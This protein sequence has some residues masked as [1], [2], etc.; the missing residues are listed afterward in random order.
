MILYDIKNLPIN[1]YNAMAVMLSGNM[2][3]EPIFTTFPAASKMT[4]T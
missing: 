4:I 3:L 2:K 1:G